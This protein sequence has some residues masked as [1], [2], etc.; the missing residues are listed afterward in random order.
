MTMID[1]GYAATLEE[2]QDVIEN[3]TGAAMASHEELNKDKHFDPSIVQ[4]GGMQAKI[5]LEAR[6][7]TD[8]SFVHDIR[9][10]WDAAPAR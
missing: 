10:Y 8:G 9:F 3:L 6:A 4:L 7:L 1:F 2:L 5:V